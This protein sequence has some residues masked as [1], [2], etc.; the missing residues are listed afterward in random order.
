MAV[1]ACNELERE[2]ERETETERDHEA[3]LILASTLCRRYRMNFF[4]TIYVLRQ[5]LCFFF[6]SDVTFEIITIIIK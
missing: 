6:P 5:N 3:W 1:R 4:V 2:R